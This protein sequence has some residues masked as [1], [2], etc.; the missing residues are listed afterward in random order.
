MLKKTVMITLTSFL[1]SL[2]LVHQ[3][4]S[5]DFQI[6]QDG[7]GFKVVDSTNNPVE[8]LSSREEVGQSL[9]YVRND[10]GEIGLLLTLEWVSSKNKTAKMTYTET[11][12]VVDAQGNTVVF[13]STTGFD[14]TPTAEDF[15]RTPFV[16]IMSTKNSVT[17]RISDDFKEGYVYEDTSTGQKLH[18][19]ELTVNN[20]AP[21]SHHTFKLQGHLQ[22]S[23][24]DTANTV[25][26]SA[27]TEID[28]SAS[29]DLIKDPEF[30]SLSFDAP[31]LSEEH[32]IKPDVSS[33]PYHDSPLGS[34]VHLTYIPTDSVTIEPHI[35]G[36]IG[37]NNSITFS[38]DNRGDITPNPWVFQPHRTAIKVLSNWHNPIDQRIYWFKSVGATKKL[39]NG[40]VVE[41]RTASDAGIAVN[42]LWSNN[43]AS[44][45]EINHSVGNPF[46]SLGSIAYQETVQIW[47]FG[48]VA[49]NGSHFGVPNHEAYGSKT[50]NSF[51]QQVFQKVFSFGSPNYTCLIHFP[52]CKKTYQG[53]VH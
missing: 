50:I 13:G 1:L 46:C 34:W 11:P 26:P 5:P 49:A 38:G 35:F 30:I 2:F 20:L 36:Q 32:I 22:N 39:E 8:I 21:G 40:A 23:S 12:P 41:T 52:H 31:T 9:F 19:N 28:T 33:V 43:G 10:S 6:V 25:K 14:I 17:I 51:G 24:P 4:E 44:G 42:N 48:M 37:C 18:N 7:Q 27:N 45:F 16:A 29:L 53:N 15:E 47:R 3:E